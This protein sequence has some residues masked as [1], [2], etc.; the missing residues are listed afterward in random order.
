LRETDYDV[1]AIMGG[2]YGDGIIAC[3]RRFSREWVARL[4]G[5]HRD[6]VRG[7][8]APARRRARARA[9]T[10]I[11]SRCIRNACAASST[12]RIPGCGGLPAV[13]GE[14]YKVVEAGFDI[15]FPGAMHQPWHR[16]FPRRRRRCRAAA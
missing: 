2:L 3:K 11:T 13:L 15:P 4:E 6:P 8:E 9:A 12:G 5:R 14:G 10:A 1:A 16:D 7:G